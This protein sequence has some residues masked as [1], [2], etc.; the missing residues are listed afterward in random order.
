[1]EGLCEELM[2]EVCCCKC[3]FTS[4]MGIGHPLRLERPSTFGKRL[5]SLLA[6]GQPTFCAPISQV[7]PLYYLSIYVISLCFCIEGCCICLGFLGFWAIFLGFRINRVVGCWQPGFCWRAFW[8][9]QKLQLLFHLHVGRRRTRICITMSTVLGMA[10]LHSLCLLRAPEEG[11]G[12]TFLHG[13][14]LVDAAS[15]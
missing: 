6:C 3:M 8:S 7:C 10:F 14:M 9:L 13:V 12:E 11:L 1:M 4:G 15:S 2:V 5:R